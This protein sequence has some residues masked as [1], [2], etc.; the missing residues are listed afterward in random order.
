MMQNKTRWVPLKDY[1]IQCDDRNSDNKYGLDSVRGISVNKEIIATKANMDGVILTPYKLFKHN[2]FCYVTVTSRNSNKITI[3]INP[4][5]DTYI[6]SSSYEVFRVKDESVLMPEYLYLIFCRPE[7]DRYARFHSWGSARETF[8]FSD[9]ERVEIPLPDIE[10]QQNIVNTWKHLRE[11]KEQNEAIAEPLFELCKS[12]LQ[13][14][15]KDCAKQSLGSFIEPCDERNSDL[16]VQLSQGI[17]NTKV[18]Q[19]PKQVAVNSQSD[20]IVRTGQFAYNRATTRNGEKISIAYREG[21]DCTVSSAYQVF[22]IKSHEEL[23]PYYLWLW[24]MRPEFDRYARYMSK[25]SAHEFFE[26]D[27]MCRVEIP[28]PNIEV[29][30]ALAN[31]FLCAKEAKRIAEEADKL[32]REIC[33]ALIQK[34]IHE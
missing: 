33:P 1:I 8:S 21:P 7:F 6:V 30:N 26:Y 19:S 18:F 15:K 12:K 9:M 14:L 23:N 5:F 2:Q 10:T 4:D 25:G 16:S 31:I 20:K 11:V 29:Q 32:S 22:A 24:F 27:E 3:S 13:E 28:L 34:V 17:A